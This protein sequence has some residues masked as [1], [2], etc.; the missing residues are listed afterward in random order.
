MT[1]KFFPHTDEEEFSMLHKIG[2]KYRE[3]L[4]VD[5]PESIQFK[6]DYDLPWSMS[7]I[8]I[9]QFF[10][11]LGKKNEQLTVFVGAG[12]YDHYTPAI[13]LSLIER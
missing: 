5:I 10:N 12:V 8:E 1:F 13:I 6:N 2:A 4:F 11:K 9:R 3:D 7:E